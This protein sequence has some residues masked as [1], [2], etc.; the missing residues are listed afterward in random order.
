MTRTTLTR[1]SPA[2]ANRNETDV[3]VCSAGQPALRSAGD[4]ARFACFAAGAVWL[5]AAIRRLAAT[6]RGRVESG[7]V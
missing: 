2:D 7:K 6:G 1:I 4:E 3:T 5:V